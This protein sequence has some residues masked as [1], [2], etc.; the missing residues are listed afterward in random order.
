MEEGERLKAIGVSAAWGFEQKALD[1]DRTLT[2]K[3][4]QASVAGSKQK[5]HTVNEST[6]KLNQQ[7]VSSYSGSLP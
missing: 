6:S 4:T 1:I 5:L 3:M 7:S 2:R